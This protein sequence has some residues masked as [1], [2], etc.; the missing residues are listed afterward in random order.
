MKFIG[1]SLLDCT[2]HYQLDELCGF[3]KDQRWQLKYK[4]SIDGFKASDFHAKCDGIANTL[5]VIKSKNGNVFGGFTEKGWLSR[6]GF[7]T[8][9]SA[10]IF[11]LVNEDSNPFKVNCSNGGQYGIC[12]NADKG[13]VFGGDGK[14]LRDIVIRS[15]SNTL[16]KGYSDFGYSYQH[17][18][19]QKET[20]KAKSILAGSFGFDIEEIEIYAKTN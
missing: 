11:S 18:D 6:G 15:D 5:T 13:P 16:Q 3:P 4:A 14:H 20:V 17:P 10:F 12:Y 2:L 1:S 9:P 7:V 19:Y 8:D